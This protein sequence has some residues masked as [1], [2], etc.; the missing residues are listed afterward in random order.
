MKVRIRLRMKNGKLMG[1][2][3]VELCPQARRR[4]RHHVPRAV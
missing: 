1:S 3:V 4:A 2:R